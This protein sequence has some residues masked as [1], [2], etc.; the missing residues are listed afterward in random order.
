MNVLTRSVMASALTILTA[1]GSSPSANGEFGRIN[2]SLFVD[3]VADSPDLTESSVITG[4]QQRVYTTLTDDGWRKVKDPEALTH[5]VTPTTGVTLYEIEAESGVKD[6]L[7]TV[8]VAGTYTFETY[9]DDDL[10]ERISLDFDDPASFELITWT[11]APYGETFDK[12]E[13][14]GTVNVEIGTQ[15]SFLPV[16]LNAG[17]SRLL[18]DLHADLVADPADAIAPDYTV[19]PYEQGVIALPEPLNIYFVRPGEVGITLTDPVS[20]ASATMNFAVD[21]VD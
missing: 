5:S 2:Y 12:V 19:K 3:Y 9:E 1:C 10:F 16:P 8:D 18:G 14:E 21:A 13:T 11:R 15:A 6:M 17:G 4:H 20:K 7:V